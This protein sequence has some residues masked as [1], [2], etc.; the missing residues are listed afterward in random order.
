MKKHTVIDERILTQQRKIN[1]EALVVL[2]TLL[3][4]A[5]LIQSA[6]LNRPFHEYW[7]ELATFLI[8]ST[9]LIVRYLIV[10]LNI[11]TNGQHMPLLV[12]TVVALIVNILNGFT[13]YTRYNNFYLKDGLGT[14]VAV[15]A[16]T[17]LSAFL[18][19]YVVATIVNQLNQHRQAAI[20]KKLDE[21]EK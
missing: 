2:M 14:F 12:S 1:S 3:G 4:V 9:Y 15:L 16:I 19:T 17:F 5:V 18:L 8:T 6:L 21:I 20:N 7:I 11:S 13:N 10:G